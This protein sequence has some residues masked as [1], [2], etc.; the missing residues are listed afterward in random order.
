MKIILNTFGIME[1]KKFNKIIEGM[2]EFEW[3]TNERVIKM[4]T[5]RQNEIKYLYDLKEKMKITVSQQF[6]LDKLTE[7]NK[8]WLHFEIQEVDTSRKWA[9]GDY[10][11]SK[12]IQ[13]LDVVDEE[14][15][16]YGFI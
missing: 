15:N 2:Y 14:L 5:K 1:D 6:R 3:R 13:Y 4:I 12:Y 7:R 11:T 8:N 10:D 9:I 16:F